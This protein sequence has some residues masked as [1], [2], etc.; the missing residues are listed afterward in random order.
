MKLPTGS[1]TTKPVDDKWMLLAYFVEESWHPDDTARNIANLESVR[2]GEKSFA[3]IQP[4]NIQWSFG[5]FSGSFECDKDTAYLDASSDV[6]YES[7]I[8]PLQEVIDLL[9]EWKAFSEAS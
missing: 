4:P 1:C 2:S 3:D 8:L 7:L 9:K 5:N 6:R